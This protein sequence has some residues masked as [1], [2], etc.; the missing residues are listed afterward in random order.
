MQIWSWL[1]IILSLGRSSLSTGEAGERRAE[2]F[3]RARG[4]RVLARNWRNPRDRR[5]ELDLVCRDGDILVF[6]EVKTRAANALVSGFYAVDG[7]KKEV[8]RRAA[9]AYMKALAPINRPN[10]FRFDV[11]EVSSD[12]SDGDLGVRQYE[13]VP[14]FSKFYRP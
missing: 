9:D 2:A 1:K 10:T 3:L 5:D 6:V 4:Y 11:V 14:L 8:V 13:N 7:R 12:F